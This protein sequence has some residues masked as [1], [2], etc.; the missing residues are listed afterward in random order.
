MTSQIP[1]SANPDLSSQNDSDKRPSLVSTS[2]LTKGNVYTIE[3][4]TVDQLLAEPIVQ[5]LMCCDHT[6]ETAIRSLLDR[7]THHVPPK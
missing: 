6:D 4:P 2:S 3:E 1:Q 5:Q 7:A